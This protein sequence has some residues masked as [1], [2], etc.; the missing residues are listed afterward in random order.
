MANNGQA[1]GGFDTLAAARAMEAAGVERRQAESI[2]MTMRDAVTFGA[3]T[4]ADIGDVR[5]ENAGAKAELKEDIADVR[6]EIAG[7][8]EEVADVRKEIADVRKEIAGVREEVAGLKADMANL[9]VRLMKVIFA[10]AGGQAA[11]IVTLLK[12]LG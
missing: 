12:L 2:A 6:K 5:R 3:A 9:E 7:V 1:A 4:K 10:V 8:R 11:V